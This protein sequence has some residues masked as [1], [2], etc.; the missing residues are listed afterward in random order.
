MSDLPYWY[1]KGRTTTPIDIPGKG[2]QVLTPRAEF[3]APTSSVSHLLKAKLVVR[4]SD[5]NRVEK[6]PEEKSK[7]MPLDLPKSFG[8]E[9]KVETETKND[10]SESPCEDNVIASKTDS[11]EDGEGTSLELPM[12]K[13]RETSHRKRRKKSDV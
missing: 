11:Q 3:Y 2:P 12:E 6:R 10:S 1:Y 13:E 5:P 9:R 7:E 4:R 8:E